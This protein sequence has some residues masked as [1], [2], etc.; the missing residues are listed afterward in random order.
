MYF[1]AIITETQTPQKYVGEPACLH[2]V[3]GDYGSLDVPLLNA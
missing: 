2:V 1:D 3:L